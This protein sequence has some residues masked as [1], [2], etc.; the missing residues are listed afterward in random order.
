MNAYEEGRFKKLISEKFY[1]FIPAIVQFVFGGLFSAFFVFYSRSGSFVASWPFIVM[2]GAL[3]VGNEFVQKHYARLTFQVSVFYVIIFSYLIFLVPI[4]TKD[5]GVKSFLISGLTS[6][7]LLG[8]FIQI[9]LRLTTKK[10]KEQRNKI[11]IYI[12]SIFVFINFL[13]FT[14]SIPPIPLS[15]QDIG[16]Y[17]AVS[18]VGGNY[19]V[20][21]EKQSNW[22][23]L[24]GSKVH[25]NKG[26]ELYVWS[27]IFAPTKINTNIVHKWQYYDET[28]G[29]WVDAGTIR[30]PITGGRDGGYRGYSAKQ[31]KEFGDWRVSVENERG[32][33]IGRINF[34]VVGNLKNVELIKE[35]K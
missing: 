28:K 32:Q 18:R 11:R 1:L 12:V 23:R 25:I 34:E 19:E 3:L 13:Y 17:H 29:D 30:F 14:N 24:F 8:L 9:L 21:E 6:L 16:V 15:L 26:E 20:I 2:L 27:S 10:V 31:I 5:I 7:V 4:I 22:K 35:L 33:L